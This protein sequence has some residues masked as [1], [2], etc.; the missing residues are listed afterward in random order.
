LISTALRL[1]SNLQQG[2][3]HRRLSGISVTE[4]DGFP[5][6]VSTIAIGFPALGREAA[7]E[8][9]LGRLEALVASLTDRVATLEQR[10]ALMDGRTAT[11]SAATRTTQDKSAII[12]HLE[13]RHLQRAGA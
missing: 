12:G 4:T 11:A 7:M 5:P 8:D 6:I 1:G 9:R 3:R 10:L 13:K 2:R